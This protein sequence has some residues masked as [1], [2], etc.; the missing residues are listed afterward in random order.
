MKTRTLILCHIFLWIF[1]ISSFLMIPIQVR[2]LSAKDMEQMSTLTMII[3]PLCF[4]IGYLGAIVT[5]RRKIF[6]SACG[7]SFLLIYAILYILSKQYFAFAL[8][9]I[10]T[11]VVWLAIGFVFRVGIDWF[12]KKNE[13]IVLRKQYLELKLRLLRSRLNPHFLYNSLHNIDVLI[14]KSPQKASDSL[15]QLSEIMRYMLNEPESLFVD[16]RQEIEF[17][18]RYIELE[19]LR[20]KNADFVCLEVD[21]EIKDVQVASMIFMPFVE[22]AIKYA[23]KT[24]D[25]CGVFIKFK[26]EEHFIHFYCRNY[27]DN[28]SSK[29][30][31]RSSTGLKM[32]QEHLESLYRNKYDLSIMQGQRE[33]EVS[34]KI[35]RNG[36]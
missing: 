21:G 25:D 18:G 13:N 31:N 30:E 4:Y 19:K 17:I 9:L 29:G 1:F 23:S 34:L 16:L 33:F 27:F 6:L 28:H 32:V 20:F 26:T 14:S 7:I 11:V 12:K 2:L 8:A 24:L 36:Y 35:K 15:I 22:N 5:S 10:P 3:S